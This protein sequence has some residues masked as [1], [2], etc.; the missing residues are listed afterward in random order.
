MLS[1]GYTSGA[2]AARLAG[3]HSARWLRQDCGPIASKPLPVAAF[4]VVLHAAARARRHRPS[5]QIVKPSACGLS[6]PAKE[7][8]SRQD[9]TLARAAETASNLPSGSDLRHLEALVVVHRHLV[10]EV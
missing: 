8:R 3:N 5:Q 10:H 1:I 6:L 4:Q 9:A 7:S 2:Q